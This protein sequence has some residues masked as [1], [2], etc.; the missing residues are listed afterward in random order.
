MVRLKLAIPVVLLIV[1]VVMATVFS[2]E[3][4]ER[5]QTNFKGPK[6][7]HSPEDTETAK[8]FKFK[9][10]F[11]KLGK[12]FQLN[13]GRKKKPVVTEG[14]AVS[15]KPPSKTSSERPPSRKRPIK[16]PDEV[17]KRP[18]TEEMDKDLREGEK[19][20]EKIATGPPQTN[21]RPSDDKKHEQPQV[22]GESEERRIEK[23]AETSSVRPSARKRPIKKP[24]EV[25]KEPMAEEIDSGPPQT[26]TRPSGRKNRMKPQ[27]EEAGGETDERR[28]ET[29]QTRKTGKGPVQPQAG[30]TPAKTRGGGPPPKYPIQIQV[31]IDDIL[32]TSVISEACV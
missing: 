17:E 3:D 10:A 21:T 28:T 32:A 27:V 23:P 31:I 29:P 6:K 30:A 5:R 4:I 25:E 9:K 14:P 8:K 13:D 7:L 26:K 15:E 22:G 2:E 19:T 20:V 24:D 18:T 16:K 12:P 11:K 1:A